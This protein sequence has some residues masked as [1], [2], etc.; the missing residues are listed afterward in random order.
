MAV[1]GLHMPHLDPASSGSSSCCLPKLPTPCPESLPR[2]QH[3]VPVMPRKIDG[4]MCVSYSMEASKSSLHPLPVRYETRNR[5]KMISASDFCLVIFGVHLN[6]LSIIEVKVFLWSMKWSYRSPNVHV[7]PRKID[8]PYYMDAF[9]SSLHP[10][11]IRYETR[12]WCKMISTSD[13]CLV[14]FGAHLNILSII[15][16]KVFCGQWSGH[17]GLPIVLVIPTPCPKTLGCNTTYLSCL[18]R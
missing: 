1:P 6:I 5:C 13:F 10:L 14:I 4:R 3:H 7:V 11:P 12:N 15:E 8:V 16:V 2:L 9:K 17:I 18:A